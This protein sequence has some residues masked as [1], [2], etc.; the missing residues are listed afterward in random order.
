MA[1]VTTSR[2]P[3]RILI[4]VLI[5]Q[6]LEL[7]PTAHRGVNLR[8]LTLMDLMSQP[9]TLQVCRFFHLSFFADAF[10]VT[11]CTVNNQDDCLAINKGTSI[12]F[13]NNV[14]EGIGHGISIVSMIIFLL[15]R[16]SPI[17]FH[18]NRALLLAALPFPELQSAETLLL[19]RE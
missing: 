19:E 5:I 4:H 3:V 8:E 1:S 10:P 13:S 6:L 11:G 9:T 17:I 2:F 18:L 7:R 15:P 16:H 12:T 14:C